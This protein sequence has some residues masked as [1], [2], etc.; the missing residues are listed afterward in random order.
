MTYIKL[1]LQTG[2][3]TIIS[4]IFTEIVEKVNLELTDISQPS[5]LCKFELGTDLIFYNCSD[6]DSVIDITSALIVARPTR[7]TNNVINMIFGSAGLFGMV[8]NATN[9]Y[10]STSCFGHPK[11][12][13]APLENT[14]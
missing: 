13:V 7:S 10:F 2:L 3:A 4:E 9:Y 1:V 6:P 14:I 12:T 11:T 8:L 5:V